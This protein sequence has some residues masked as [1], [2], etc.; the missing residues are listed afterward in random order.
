MIAI[1]LLLLFFVF[2]GVFAARL[3]GRTHVLLIAGIVVM[4]AYEVFQLHGM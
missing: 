2:L 3:R 4:L 1:G